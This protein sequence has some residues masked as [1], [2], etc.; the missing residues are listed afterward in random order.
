[1]LYGF[2]CSNH[3]DCVAAS[4]C[5]R[6]ADSFG[7][8]FSAKEVR[9]EKSNAKKTQV[10]ISGARCH[11]KFGIF[12]KGKNQDLLQ[13][14]VTFYGVFFRVASG[15]YLGFPFCQHFSNWFRKF[16][17]TC[18]KLKWFFSHL[19][20]SLFKITCARFDRWQEITFLLPF[21]FFPLWTSMVPIMNSK[22]MKET[23]SPK[24]ASS[25]CSHVKWEVLNNESSRERGI[26][27]HSF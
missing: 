21:W 11:Q 1:M 27:C 2:N 9:K 22:S 14:P 12:Y 17:F 5:M 25:P 10:F 6:I 3:C 20:L 4:G 8:F 23:P 16:L 18:T 26:I 19:P 24:N 13:C 7:F 15:K